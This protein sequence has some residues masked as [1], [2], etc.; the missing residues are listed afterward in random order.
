[1]IEALL[2]I[3]T[4]FLAYNNGANDN[5]K[6]VATLYG[7]GTLGFKTALTLATITTFLGSIAAIF[8]ANGLIQSFSGKGL[9][10]QEIAGSMD[11]LIAVGFGAGFTVLLA[12]R[13]GFPVSTTHS[14]VGGL[15]GAGIMAVGMDINF[16]KLGNAFFI[17]LL[18]SPFIAFA[19]GM[20]VYFLFKKSKKSFALTKESCVCLGKKK[21][22]VPVSKLNDNQLIYLA[23]NMNIIKDDNVHLEIAKH[24][25]CVKVYTNK[26][27]GISLQKVLDN[28]HILS[29][30]AVSFA[31]GLNDTPKI[32]GLLVAAH[33]LDIKYGMVA[34]A[35][36][37][38]IGGILNSKLVAQTMSKKITKLNHGQG[39]CANLVT[40]FL[41]IVASKFG[42]PVSTTHVSV[43][44]IF[45]IGIIS[46]NYN[47]KV[48]K[49]ILLSWLV[50]LP[51]GMVFSSIAYIIVTKI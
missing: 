51:I 11:F 27:F 49:S 36:G 23:S 7:S 42:I 46:K 21:Q 17:P 33:T 3:A 44:S 37:M 6:G 20:I 9:V 1:M 2:V 34:I 38:A 32:A 43:G 30:A 8:I 48:I 39:F 35:I 16:S 10:P 50:T 19:L 40:S 29:A 15:M 28:L 14:L 41:V 25:E 22:Y 45:G 26:V 12:T 5:F 4:I 31:R 18:V 13:L 24:E 47:S